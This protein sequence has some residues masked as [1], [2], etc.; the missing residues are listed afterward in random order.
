MIILLEVGQGFCL[1]H[2][3]LAFGLFGI[4]RI[5]WSTLGHVRWVQVVQKAELTLGG[6]V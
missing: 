1:G 4:I 6:G 3:R 5:T 2:A